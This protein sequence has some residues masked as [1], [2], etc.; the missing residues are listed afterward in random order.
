M[1]ILFTSLI[2]WMVGFPSFSQTPPPII[3][4]HLHALPADFYGTPPVGMCAPFANWSVMDPQKG[5]R[6]YFESAVAKN[7]N[8]AGDKL[9]SPLSD[10]SL[11]K[12]TLKILRKYNI[13]GVTSGSYARV[14]KWEKFAPERIIPAVLFS[15]GA[16]ILIDTLRK[17]FT[18]GDLQVF[19]EIAVQYEGIKLS[20]SIMEP[21]LEMAE[22]LDIPILVHI[23]PGPP[24]VAYY[25]SP[26]YRA[27]LHSVLQLE[28]VLLL[29]PKLRVCIAHAGWPMINDMIALLYA[30]P[31]VYV[32]IGILCYA[33]P[34]K[35]FYRYLNRL[36]TAG[37]GKRICFGSDHMIWPQAIE[38]GIANIRK[39]PF[40]T[41]EQK[42]DIL[43]NNA[44]R[45]LRLDS[46]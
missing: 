8:C 41:E 18:N 34:K 36:I 46:P 22:E 17:R 15:V 6:H 3:D 16:H 44:A 31:Q 9:W 39:A 5:G 21:Y 32:D 11:R 19:G 42:R 28:E 43:Y 25:G 29:H 45:F 2:F 1:R 35:E 10:E 4:M 37:F 12:Q 38:I 30:H 20:D 7:L 13:T 23:G 24:G 26:N 27:K 33:F 14:K 40:L